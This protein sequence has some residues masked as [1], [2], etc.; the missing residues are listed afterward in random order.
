MGLFTFEDNLFT[1][2]V[3]LFARFGRWSGS[4][5]NPWRL[6]LLFVLGAALIGALI[7]GVLYAEEEN[8]ISELCTFRSAWVCVGEMGRR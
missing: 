3:K 6:V 2:N 8:D 7:P 1:F 4:D 5:K